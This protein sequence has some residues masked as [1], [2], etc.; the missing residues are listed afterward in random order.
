MITR[1][2]KILYNITIPSSI[3]DTKKLDITSSE[4]S[5]ILIMCNAWY[6]GALANFEVVE[7]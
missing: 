3:I 1:K 2:E 4:V 6:E 7:R 5:Y